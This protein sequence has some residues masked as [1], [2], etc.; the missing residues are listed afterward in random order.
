MD[1][2]TINITD[3]SGAEHALEAPLD[4]QLTLMELCRAAELPVKGTCGGMALCS[5]CHV[6]VTSHHEL[7]PPRVDEEDMLDQAF[8]V[9]PNSRLGCQIMLSAAHHGLCVTLAPDT[10]E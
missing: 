3:R 10:E 6:Y 1:H 9:K 4:I 2:I 8:F 5:S 7:E